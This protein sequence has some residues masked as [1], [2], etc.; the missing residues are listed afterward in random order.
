PV[1]KNLV[2]IFQL[3]E[4]ARKDPVANPALRPAEVRVIALVGAGVMGGGIAELASR[5][6][7]TVRLRD[8][9]PASITHALRT[10][11]GI[12][13]ERGA[14]TSDQTLV[15]AVA[16]ARR[17]GKTPVLVQDAPGFVVDRILMPYLREALHLLEEGYGLAEIDA[18]MK[19]F[20]MPMGPFEVVDE[21]GLVV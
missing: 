3:S 19:R 11:R 15:T 2:R 1:S 17:L 9:Q 20:G 4:R 13:E 6:G 14:R 21:V 16:L 7:L 8:L 10:V 5:N 12:I 18:A